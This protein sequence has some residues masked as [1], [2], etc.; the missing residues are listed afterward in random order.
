MSVMKP[1][2][3]EPI[4]PIDQRVFGSSI[5]DQIYDASY[6]MQFSVSIPNWPMPPSVLRDSIKCILQRVCDINVPYPLNNQQKQRVQELVA[7][8]DEYCRQMG[9][10]PLPVSSFPPISS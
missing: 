4:L 6:C 7:R 1:P 8:T 3:N 9:L 2:L 10:L 5:D